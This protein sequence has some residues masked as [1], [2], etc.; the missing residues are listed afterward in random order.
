MMTKKHARWLLALGLAALVAGCSPSLAPATP[1][2]EGS[3]L[4]TV[5][6]PART[7]LLPAMA[8]SLRVTVHTARGFQQSR[9]LNRPAAGGASTVLFDPVPVGA[10]TITAAAY[11]QPEAGGTAQAAGVTEVTIAANQRADVALTIAT[12]IVRLVIA[13]A[14]PSLQVGDSLLLTATPVDASGAVVLTPPGTIAWS[15][16]GAATVSATGG[17]LTGV[18]PGT[19]QV[20]AAETESGVASTVTATVSAR[21]VGKIAFLSTRDGNSEIYIMNPDGTDQRRLTNNP[22]NENEISFS[23]DGRRI[24]FISDRNGPFH[25]F[26]MNSDG[27]DVRQL[28]NGSRDDW[29]PIFTPDSTEILFFRTESAGDELYIMNADGTNQ[30]RLTNNTVADV[31]PSMTPDGQWIIFERMVGNAYDLFRMRRDGSGVQNLTNAPPDDWYHCISPDGTKIVYTEGTHLTTINIDGTGRRQL[32][33]PSGYRDW[34][35]WYSPDG[36]FIAFAS[37]REGNQYDIYVMDSD[38][39]NPRRLTTSTSLDHYPVWGP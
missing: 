26:I 20:T 13:P 24:L 15:A 34:R 7:R 5:R 30:R 16:T 25:I 36:R 27:T 22:A 29:G 14:T 32:T 38:G 28:T 10:L 6:W 12:T 9:V 11:P 39:Q 2:D 35:P 17:V 33:F 4:L 8:E 19:A 37:N 23:P 21:L 3:A 18:E 1:A 31:L